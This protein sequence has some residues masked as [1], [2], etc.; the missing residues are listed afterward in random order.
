MR[1]Q[2]ALPRPTLHCH[3]HHL[4]R[5]RQPVFLACV[6]RCVRAPISFHLHAST[7]MHTPRR[8]RARGSHTTLVQARDL[9]PA[10]LAGAAGVSREARAARGATSLLSASSISAL[11][12]CSAQMPARQAHG[13]RQV[14]ETETQV[15]AEAETKTR[16]PTIAQE[17][18]RARAQVQRRVITYT[19]TRHQIRG[20][21][22]RNALLSIPCHALQVM[23]TG[24]ANM[25]VF[26]RAS[27]QHT[28]CIRLVCA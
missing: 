23:A 9:A 10:H 7:R 12:S 2:L 19:K 20:S 26:E 25:I 4:F 16:A 1:R 21:R 13:G 18:T 17:D 28:S 8:A 14:A 22:V 15:E 6:L 3:P 27:I 24:Q 5:L 11:R